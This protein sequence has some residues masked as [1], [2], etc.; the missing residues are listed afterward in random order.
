MLGRWK[1]TGFDDIKEIH[2]DGHHGDNEIRR[3]LQQ[4]IE[5]IVDA[6]TRERNETGGWNRERTMQKVGSIPATVYYDWIAEWQRQGKIALGDP[7]FSREVNRL[8]A[9]RL[10]DSDYSKFRTYG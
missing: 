5:P 3:V 6:N 10:R 8:C 2:L 7:N 9:A 4:D 1:H